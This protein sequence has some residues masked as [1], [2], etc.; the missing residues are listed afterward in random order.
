MAKKRERP[1]LARC[2]RVAGSMAAGHVMY[3]LMFWKPTREINGRMWFAKSIAELVYETGLTH[4]QVKTALSKLRKMGFIKTEQ[5]L[6]HGR[7]VNHILVTAE[8]QKAMEADAGESLE[9]LLESSHE[10]LLE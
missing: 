5:H 9:G 10:G 4:K 7:N 6:F 3:R 2:I 8:F 1:H